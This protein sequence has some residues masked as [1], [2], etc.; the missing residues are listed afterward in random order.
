MNSKK[1]Y[2]SLGAMLKAGDFE[3]LLDDLNQMLSS[4]ELKNFSKTTP[5][6][7]ISEFD[8]LL[9]YFPQ[10]AC[11][12][13]K[14]E[15]GTTEQ[16]KEIQPKAME[17]LEF[18]LKN[19][20]NPNAYMKNGESCYLKACQ[21]DNTEILKY[22][23][24]N[25]YSKADLTHTDGMGNNGLLYATLSESTEMME[26]LVKELG[27][28]INHKNFLSNNETC[29]HYACGHM[30]EK[31]VDKL[32]ELGADPT[33]LDN[34]GMKPF[35]MILA[36]YDEDVID[37]YDQNDPEDMEELQKAKDLYNKVEELTKSFAANKKSKL[38]TKF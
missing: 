16:T 12:S 37:E 2:K 28:D 13:I 32:L 38:K 22:L 29:L 8:D 35:E 10:Y 34:Y 23:V 30:K 6:N 14:K 5:Q 7:P 24:D 33:L 3:T 15:D 31:S 21:I 19:G 26:F 25:K 36:A 17:F 4:G 11:K 1:T 27:F 9:F 20:A 18:A